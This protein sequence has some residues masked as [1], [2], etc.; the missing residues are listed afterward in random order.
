[1]NKRAVLIAGPTASGKSGFAIALAKK[2]NGHIINADS[3]QVYEGLRV[4]TARP[5]PA[6]EKT[7]P[8]HLYGHIPAATRYSVGS[9]LRDVE[10]LLPTFKKTGKTPIFVGGTGLYFKALTE[11]LATLPEFTPEQFNRFVTNLA[12]LPTQSLQKRLKHEDPVGSG[13]IE[14]GDRQRT[15]RALMVLELTGQN[16]SDWQQQSQSQALL[17]LKVC[18]PIVLMPQDRAWLYSRIDTRFEQMVNE[19]GGAKEAHALLAREIS[20]DLPLMRAIGMPHFYKLATNN[21]GTNMDNVVSLSQRD[22]RRYAKRQMTW[23]RNQMNHWPRLDPMIWEQ[24]PDKMLKDLDQ[25]AQELE[26]QG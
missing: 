3:M 9:W 4:L 17:Q 12:D 1:M 6:E 24:Q 26:K 8:H 14:R 10:T 21:P 7:V 16:L 19:D 20:P 5:S 22:T 18:L 15:L 25:I 2:I 13:R 23:F 11:G